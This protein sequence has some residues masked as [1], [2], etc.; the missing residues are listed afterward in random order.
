MNNWTFD[1]WAYILNSIALDIVKYLETI[2]LKG[3]S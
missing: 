3:P 1:D 2:L